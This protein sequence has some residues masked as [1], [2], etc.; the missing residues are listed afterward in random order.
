MFSGVVFSHDEYVVDVFVD[1]M[2]WSVDVILCVCIRFL[3]YGY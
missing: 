3:R 2:C 1:E